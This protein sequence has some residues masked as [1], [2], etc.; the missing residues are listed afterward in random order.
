MAKE[1]SI[2]RAQQGP[3]VIFEQLDDGNKKMALA[4]RHA[5]AC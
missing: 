2:P 4:R 1:A 5:S 3:V